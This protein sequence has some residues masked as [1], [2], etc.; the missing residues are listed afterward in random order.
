MFELIL[1][2]QKVRA[3]SN[4]IPLEVKTHKQ[5]YLIVPRTRLRAMGDRYFR[6]TAARAWNSL[7]VSGTTTTSL[8]SFNLKTFLFTKSFP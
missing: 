7:P 5:S 1:R 4:F 6:V 3:C 2:L 8:T